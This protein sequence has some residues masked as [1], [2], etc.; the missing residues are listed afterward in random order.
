MSS[1]FVRYS[2]EIETFDPKLSEYMTR[3]ID[4]WET[5]V[6]ESPTREGS[7]RAVRGAHAKTIGVARA[8]VEILGDAQAPYAQG[9][10]AKP[11][12]HDAL[13]RFSSASNHLGPDALLGPVLGF[14]IKIFDVA[15]TKLVEDEPDSTTFDLVLKNNPTF[16][17]NTAKHYLFIQEIADQAATYLA[18]GRAGF[19][20]LMTDF[21]TGKGTLQRDDWAWDELFA[22]VKLATQ[23]P[24]RNPLLSTYWTMAAVRHGDHIAKIRVASTAESAENA[25]HRQLD[26]DGGPDVFGPTLVDELQAH[27]FDFD[28]QV[29][30]CT[31][32]TAMPVNDVT[33]E[34]PEKLS[35]FVIVGRVHLPRQDISRPENVEKGDALAFNQWRVTSDHRPLGEIMDVR[36]IYTA[37]AKARR[38]L[39]QQPQHEPTSADEVLTLPRDALCGNPLKP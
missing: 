30:L 21:V 19:H 10:Y 11:G 4:F 6:R 5:L 34:W 18:R 12:R 38:T 3:I 20:E 33:V 24:V 25:I 15:G 28:L 2:P 17:A 26:L 13:I 35:P 7:G 9:I 37:S 22:F 32:L 31:D 23:T 27:A 8:Q 14:A 36:R 29:Q 1:D 16:I 39:N